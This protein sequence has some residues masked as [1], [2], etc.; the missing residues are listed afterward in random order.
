M[1]CI[2][3]GLGYGKMA[4]YVIRIRMWH[5][6]S[7]I[8]TGFGRSVINEFNI[9]NSSSLVD[10]DTPLATQSVSKRRPHV[11]ENFDSDNTDNGATDGGPFPFRSAKFQV[12]SMAICLQF[13]RLLK[14]LWILNIS[15]TP[16]PH[17]LYLTH[18][19]P[20]LRNWLSATS[21]VTSLNVIYPSSR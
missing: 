12:R 20:S 4:H 10:S 15:S 7:R 5:C 11:P 17:R 21:G 19:Y 1:A 6:E 9:N 13:F 2:V 8:G 18:H 3:Y 16:L 14:L